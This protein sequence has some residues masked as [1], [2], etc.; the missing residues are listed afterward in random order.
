M[1]TLR[2]LARILQ[3]AAAE[4]EALAAEQTTERLDW[5]DQTKSPLGSRRHIRAVRARLSAELP[6][7]GKLGRRFLLSP[8]AV[9]EELQCTGRVAPELP[10]IDEVSAMREQLALVRGGR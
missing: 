10:P 8:Q 7:A 9:A 6:G 3:A 4:C 1:L 2:H 5:V